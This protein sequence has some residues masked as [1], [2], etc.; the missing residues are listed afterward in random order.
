MKA[1][2]DPRREQKSPCQREKNELDVRSDAM[3]TGFSQNTRWRVS[4]HTTCQNRPRC[5]VDGAENRQ[6]SAIN[7]QHAPPA[8]PGAIFSRTLSRRFRR[9]S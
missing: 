4:Q 3:E 8:E 5:A 2:H 1:R 7:T 9:C 6:E